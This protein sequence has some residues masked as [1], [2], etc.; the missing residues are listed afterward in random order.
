V[1]ETRDNEGA[2][3]LPHCIARDGYG[4]PTGCPN[5]TGNHCRNPYTARGNRCA[6]VANVDWWHDDSGHDEDPAT[7]GWVEV[8]DGDAFRRIFLQADRSEGPFRWV[9]ED[10]ASWRDPETWREC[11]A[12]PFN[13]GLDAIGAL[14]LTGRGHRYVPV[15]PLSECRQV[16]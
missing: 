12:A 3:G 10:P 11:C 13:T 5:R 16:S 7:V 14:M 4:E 2:R 9:M 8:G 15:R 6:F 1:N